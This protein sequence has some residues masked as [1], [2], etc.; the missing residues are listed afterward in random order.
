[1]ALVKAIVR[2]PESYF[3]GQ[4]LNLPGS[5]VLVDEAYVS[6]ADTV[7]VEVQV[8]LKDAIIDK[9]GKVHRVVTEVVKRRVMFRPAGSVDLAA[10]V[11]T[12]QVSQPD[13]L[14][15][16]DFLKGGMPDIVAKIESGAV[17]DF[18]DAIANA[19]SLGKGRKGISEAI[20]DRMNVA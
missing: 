19:E 14:N 1:M 13:R 5:T 11:P 12:N 9:D 20:A 17:D 2:G 3:D 7:P 8:R 15:V 10:E 16:T 6:E 18:L 4:V